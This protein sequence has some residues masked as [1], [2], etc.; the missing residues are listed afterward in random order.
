MQ[1]RAC[2]GL[3]LLGLGGCAHI[4]ASLRL[5]VDGTT[6]EFKKKVPPAEEN[7]AEPAADNGAAPDAAGDDDPA[8]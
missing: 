8:R 6:V 1:L 2:L 7:E 3:I 4:P 5:D